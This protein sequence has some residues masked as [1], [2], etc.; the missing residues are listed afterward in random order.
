M[1]KNAIGHMVAPKESAGSKIRRWNLL[2]RLLCLLLAVL[3]W[4]LIVNVK[5]N[6]K[7]DTDPEI[8]LPL[9]ES[10]LHTEPAARAEW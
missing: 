8:S 6:K 9:T 7:A 4:L 1:K 5:Q 10:E 2:P 3:F